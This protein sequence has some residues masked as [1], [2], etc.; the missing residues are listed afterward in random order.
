MNGSLKIDKKLWKEEQYRFFSEHIFLYKGKKFLQN[1]VK[2]ANKITDKEFSSKNYSLTDKN[3]MVNN[4]FIFEVKL[5]RIFNNYIELIEKMAFACLK[6][7]L[8]LEADS[9]IA[10]LEQDLPK[11]DTFGTII[12]FFQKPQENLIDKKRK[13][14]RTNKKRNVSE[15]K[16]IKTIS[17]KFFKYFQNLYAVSD[18]IKSSTKFLNSLANIKDL[19]NFIYHHDYLFD[20]T[21]KQTIRIGDQEVEKNLKDYLKALKKILSKNYNKVLF[22]KMQY[23]INQLLIELQ[24][25][26]PQDWKIYAR[27]WSPIVDI[28]KPNDEVFT[29]PKSQDFKKTKNLYTLSKYKDMVNFREKNKVRHQKI[30]D[31]I[32]EFIK[33]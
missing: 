13:G 31:H 20:I 25:N 16:D 14:K 1:I 24:I 26:S 30:V 19:R 28:F 4:I 15:I 8:L 12:T 21:K 11:M 5:R 10:L 18:N 29:F 17:S 32:K 27:L 33:D 22:D 9:S 7:L 3:I 23:T 6:N 2:T